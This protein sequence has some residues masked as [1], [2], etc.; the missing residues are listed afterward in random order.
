L[1]GHWN[2][3]VSPTRRCQQLL[4]LGL[5]LAPKRTQVSLVN[6]VL[7]LRD[8]EGL[9]ER[10]VWVRFGARF[11]SKVPNYWHWL[12]GLFPNCGKSV[13]PQLNAENFVRDNWRTFAHQKYKKDRCFLWEIELLPCPDP[14]PTLSLVKT[15][16][17]SISTDFSISTFILS[18]A[19]SVP[20]P[21]VG[22]GRHVGLITDHQTSY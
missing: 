6:L 10:D 4:T 14:V 22:E 13:R 15:L 2:W 20:L 12:F 11:R 1:P 7:L 3:G 8:V 17:V 5:N 18:S 9:I 19:F 21:L 16:D